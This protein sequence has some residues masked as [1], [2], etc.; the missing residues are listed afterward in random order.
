MSETNVAGIN[1]LPVDVRGGVHHNLLAPDT[2]TFVLYAPFKPY[3]SL[4]GDF[5]HWNSRTNRMV[6]DGRGVWWTTLPHP[7]ETRY[8]FYVAVDEQSHAWVGDPYAR[9]LAWDQDGPWA[10]LPS[11][12]TPFAWNDE[13]WQTPSLRDLVIYELCVRD[14]AGYWQANRPHYGT[15]TDLVGYLDYFAEIGINAIELMPIQAFPGDSSWGYNPVF[16]FAPAQSYGKP[17]DLKQ[18]VNACHSRGIAVLLDVAFNHAW[19]DHPYYHFYP[20]MY[21]PNGEWLTDWNP[22]FHHT[23]SAINS[24]GGLDW[25]HFAAETTRYFQDIVRFWLAEYHLD[26]FRFDWVGGVDYDSRNPMAPGFDP[27][28]GIS[29]I[30]WAARQTKPDCILIAEYWQLEGTHPAKTGGKLVH[31]TAMDS[32]WNGEFHHI[33]DDVLN[34]RWAWEHQDIFRAIGGFREQGYTSAAQVINYSCSHDEVRPEHEIIFYSQRHIMRPPDMAV[35]EMARAKALLGLVTLFAAPGVPMIYAGQEFA[36][37]APRTIDFQPLHWA[38]LQNP[39]N[40][41]Y[42]ANVKRL[43]RARHTH[44]ALRS[45]HILFHSNDFAHEQIVRFQRR[46]Y[47]ND[48]ETLQDVVVVALNFSGDRITTVLPLPWTGAWTDVV[49]DKHYRPRT[50]EWQ[51]TLAPWQALL[52]IPSRIPKHFQ[53]A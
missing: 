2:V 23:P 49:A 16:Y 12:T 52:L 1:M 27:Y 32:C 30:C 28:H 13:Q 48:G 20:P 11:S 26:G 33:L 34:Q 4:V 35:Q 39:A 50:Q 41:D 45:D 22:F 31:E 51:V 5:N 42:L 24:W 3:V 43:V 36:E 38:K 40:A 8:G 25:D 6:T 29:A 14:F 19:G 37:D 46:A 47:E 7:G 15:L 10:Y 53:I 9:Q 18:L 17:D 21:G 44:P